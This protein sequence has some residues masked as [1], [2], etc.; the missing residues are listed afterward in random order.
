MVC[1]DVEVGLRGRQRRRGVAPGRP[2]GRTRSPRRAPSAGGA[3]RRRR[4]GGP[5]RRCPAPVGAPTH[6]G[7]RLARRRRWCRRSSPRGSGWCAAAA[8]TGRPCS[9]CARRRPPSRAGAATGGAARPVPPGNIDASAFTRQIG[10]SEV[11][12]RSPSAPQIRC[13]RSGASSPATRERSA[14]PRRRWT[15]RDARE[16]WI[17]RAAGTSRPRWVA[18]N[19]PHAAD[20]TPGLAAVASWCRTRPVGERLQERPRS[21]SVASWATG[22]SLPAS[23]V[24][25]TFPV[26]SV[27]LHGGRPGRP[28]GGPT[29]TSWR[30]PRR[31][32]SP[33]RWRGRAL[34]G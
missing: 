25:H 6:V 28:A 18:P 11:N 19:E 12:Q 32:A 34:E 9:R 10:S 33:D 27:V 14:R 7:D 23:T 1:C 13:A 15:A 20:V 8:P 30:P 21:S 26:V 22:P 24:W 5:A 31:A 4:T 2:R 3:G 16:L 17:R 29:G